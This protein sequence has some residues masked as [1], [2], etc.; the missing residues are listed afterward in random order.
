MYVLYVY[1]MSNTRLFEVTGEVDRGVLTPSE[2]NAPLRFGP[3]HLDQKIN[4]G[5]PMR[6]WWGGDD[7]FFLAA[8]GVVGWSQVV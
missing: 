7:T 6:M 2:H 1:L 3:R 8:D 4:F 5:C